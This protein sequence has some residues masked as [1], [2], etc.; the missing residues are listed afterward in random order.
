MNAALATTAIPDVPRL[1]MSAV[2]QTWRFMRD[3]IPL[4]ERGRAPL[5]ADRGRQRSG[6]FFVPRHGLRVQVARRAPAA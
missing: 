6:T 4:V 3:P 1:S 2:E 5:D